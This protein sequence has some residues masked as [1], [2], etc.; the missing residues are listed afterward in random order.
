MTNKENNR[1]YPLRDPENPS[2]SHSYL[3]LRS[4]IVPSTPKSGQHRNVSSITIAACVLS[5]TYGNATVS[6]IYVNIMLP[7]SISLDDP[8]PDGKVPSAITCP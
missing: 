8:L 6:A 7:N 4:S 5:A 2:R 3:S 1:Y